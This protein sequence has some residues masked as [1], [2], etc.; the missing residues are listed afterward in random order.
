M[1]LFAKFTVEFP[2]RDDKVIVPLEYE[3]FVKLY[4]FPDLSLQAVTDDVPVIVD[5]SAASSHSCKPAID[6]GVNIVEM[7]GLAFL[8]GCPAGSWL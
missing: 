5:E 1:T 3:A 8:Y 7:V 2:F 4:P 6:V